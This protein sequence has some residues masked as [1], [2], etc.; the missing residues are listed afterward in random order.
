VLRELLHG[1]LADAREFVGEVV[2]DLRQEAVLT[3]DEVLARYEGQRGDPVAVLQFVQGSTGL[4]GRAA[5]DEALK[6][7][8]E[9]EKMWAG[10]VG[11]GGV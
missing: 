1:A 4:Q 7:E 3:D 8:R 6:Y 10:R 9:M 2:G 5:V 11:E